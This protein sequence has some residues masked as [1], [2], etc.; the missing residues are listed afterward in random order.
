M[1]KSIQE[2]YRDLVST[3]TGYIACAGDV[4]VVNM[5]GF[6]INPD[7]SKGAALPTVAQGDNISTSNN[8]NNYYHI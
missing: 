5:N 2:R 7:G 1:K 3:E 6:D 4:A 8:N